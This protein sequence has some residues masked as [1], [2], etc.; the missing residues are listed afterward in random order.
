MSKIEIPKKIRAENFKEDDRA[1]A[2][3]IGAVYNEF[4]DNLY[5][6]LQ[7][8]VDFNN[9]NRQ[10][11]EVTVTL[12]SSAKLVNPPV[13]KFDLKS[14]VKAVYCGAA[15]CITSNITNP[16]GTPFITWQINNNTLIITGVTNLQANTQYSLTLELVGE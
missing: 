8:N 13:V 2:S 7:K 5:F 15:T 3:G 6:L 11:V 9:L 12:D 14:R 16:T 1:L 4:V 10:L